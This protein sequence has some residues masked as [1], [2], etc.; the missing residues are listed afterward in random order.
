MI[1]L[2]LFIPRVLALHDLDNFIAPI[3]GFEGDTPID[4]VLLLVQTP[5]C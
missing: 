1:F 4:T 5:E 2:W 3:P